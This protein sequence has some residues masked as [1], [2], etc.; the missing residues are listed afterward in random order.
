MKSHLPLG[1]FSLPPTAPLSPQ[2]T[3]N[4]LNSICVALGAQ[5]LMAAGFRVTKKQP[6]GDS[7][8]TFLALQPG[9]LSTTAALL[10]GS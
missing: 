8:I 2:A 1:D 9:S 10:S 5:T 6:T 3:F 7:A 4:V